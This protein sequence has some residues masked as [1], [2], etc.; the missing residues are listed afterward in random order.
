MVSDKFDLIEIAITLLT[1]LRFHPSFKTRVKAVEVLTP[2]IN[3][4]LFIELLSEIYLT[5]DDPK[6]LK[7]ITLDIRV[8]KEDHFRCILNK[9]AFLRH[10]INNANP[11]QLSFIEALLNTITDYGIKHPTDFRWARAELI[12]WNLS[13][14]PDNII[15]LTSTAI[16][17]LVSGFR[18]WLGPNL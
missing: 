16:D 14:A 12:K 10:E 15:S 4:E 9:L 5:S 7:D 3:G 17:K 11:Q 8:L 2:N 1:R 13:L 6:I 18:K